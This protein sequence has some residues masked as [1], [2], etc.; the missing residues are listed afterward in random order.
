MYDNESGDNFVPPEPPPNK[1]NNPVTALLLIG[2]IGAPLVWVI[3]GMLLTFE[4]AKLGIVCVLI[5]VGCFVALVVR[6]QGGGSPPRE[7]WED[8]TAL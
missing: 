6:S 8:G 4:P 3:V 2:V 5:F 1:I 7:G